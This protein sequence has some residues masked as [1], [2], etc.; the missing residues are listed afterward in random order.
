MGFIRVSVGDRVLAGGCEAVITH[1]VSAEEVIV[2]DLTAGAVRQVPV[3]T[4]RPAPPAP[5]PR[6]QTDL[7]LVSNEDWAVAQMRY[8]AVKPLLAAPRTGS[9]VL[10]EVAARTGRHQSTIYRWLRRYQR[11]GQQTALIPARTGVN[12]GH[13]RL[14]P[15]AET[16]I[17]AAIEER[18]LTPN[19]LN[20]AQLHRDV[21]LKCRSAGIPAPHVNTVRNRISRI[22]PRKLMESRFGNRA[23][24]EQFEP[25]KGHFPQPDRPLAIVQIDH[26]KLDLIVVGEVDR[27]PLARPWLTVAIDVFSR[28][29]AGFY[30]SLEAPGAAS[31]GMCAASAILPKNTLLAKWGIAT[32]W[33][34][35][36]RMA[37]IHCDNGKDF[38]GA[39]LRQACQQYGIE[40]LF[41]PV[42][43]PHYGGHI[44]RLMGT[45]AREI[46]TLPGT[47][48]SNPGERKGY[49]SEKH[50]ALT[51]GELERW[52]ARYIVEIYHQKPHS[53]LGGRTPIKVYEEGIARMGLPEL[54]ANEE[55][56]R[57]DFMPLEQRSVTV[58]GIV[59]DN[60]SYFHDVLRPWINTKEKNGR[61]RRFAVRLDPRDISTVHFFDPEL[62]QYF[63][64]PYR[65]T[66]HPPISVW[67]LREIRRRLKQEG[68]DSMNED[69][70]FRAYE[71][72]RTIEDAAVNKTKE[73]RRNIERRN[74]RQPHAAATAS[75]AAGDVAWW[76]EEIQPFREV[77]IQ[78]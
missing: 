1:V 20:A 29:V 12:P 38:R 53:G 22:Q 4:L 69:A 73:M 52:I 75:A 19:R 64:I 23:A 70:I 32:P 30:L 35:W 37:A 10:K 17:G 18:Y 14:R 58:N 46:H 45:F 15:E 71:Q 68:R 28:M 77:V 72:M 40:L 5:E 2:R 50:A 74:S 27:K 6:L 59:V 25:V 48:F 55:Q 51:T 76:E 31:A 26:T 33:P 62:K 3:R 11:E 24:Q 67:E 56:L 66:S 42:R 54:C 47:T 39:M 65:D 34:V 78:E 60:V 43:Q 21:A 9:N 8:E 44:E 57:L 13:S 41:R 61:Q 49:D 7:S 16:I 36:G 63:A